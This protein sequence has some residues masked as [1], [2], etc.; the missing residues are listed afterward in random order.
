MTYNVLSGTLSLYTTTTTI[1][2]TKKHSNGWK[3]QHLQNKN[4]NCT[5]LVSFKDQGLLC[6]QCMIS[7]T[8]LHTPTLLPEF[9]L[10]NMLLC[11]SIN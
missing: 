8:A 7:A 2:P 3:E 5:K 1:R 6:L 9:Q 10:L 4:K 11:I